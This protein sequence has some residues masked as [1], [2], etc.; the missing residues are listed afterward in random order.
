VK[1]ILH[2]LIYTAER[3]GIELWSEVHRVYEKAIKESGTTAEIHRQTQRERRR[4][5]QERKIAEELGR[6]TDEGIDVQ[7][8]RP[9]DQV[10]DDE[11]MELNANEEDLLLA[12]PQH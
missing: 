11:G 4:K 2:E 6:Q 10:S 12:S 7:D 9:Q 5:R 3:L 1:D 8:Q